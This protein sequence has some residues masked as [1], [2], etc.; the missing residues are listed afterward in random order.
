[1]VA[2]IVNY[3][4]RTDEKN[5]RIKKLPTNLEMEEFLNWLIYC[6]R[7]HISEE[8][9]WVLI[10]LQMKDI[11]DISLLNGIVGY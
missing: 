11:F 1:M 7:A 6:W 4:L 5:N 10:F 9:I 3:L 2:M 8:I